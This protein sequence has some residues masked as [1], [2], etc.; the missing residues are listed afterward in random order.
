M[1]VRRS[2]CGLFLLKFLFGLI[3]VVCCDIIK[4]QNN[5]SEK[6]MEYKFDVDSWGGQFSVPCSVATEYLKT[7]DGNYVK[8]LLSILASPARTVNS[9]VIANAC[10]LNEDVV[11]DAVI[12]W[13]SLGV[14]RIIDK[15]N[16]SAQMPTAPNPVI[17]HSPVGIVESVKPR[18]R[19]V[20]KKV[21]VSYSLQE[22]REKAEKDKELGRL[23]NEIQ[24]YL[25]RDI[26]GREM[27]IL[28]DLYEVYHFDVPTIL[29]TAEYCNTLGKYSVPYLHKLLKD[30]FEHDITTYEQAEAEI[31]RR[32]E[33]NSYESMVKRCLGLTNRLTSHQQEFV[34]RWKSAGIDESLLEIACEKCLD[35]TGGK[36]NF[37][38]IDTVIASWVNKGIK[39]PEQ[40]KADDESFGG[41]NGRF[42][43][44]EKDNSFSIDKLEKI[45]KNFVLRNEDTSQ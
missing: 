34:Q 21:V 15:N 18:E 14:L 1:Y 16:S 33:Y 4:K 8:V 11:D 40:V 25:N 10:G 23:F 6:T 37:K 28:D 3:F 45:A 12:H 27:G 41:K 17:Q 22:I 42:V 19:A 43:A 39:T 36:I 30:W 35:G 29:I 31:V 44:D 2:A 38:Y 5:K 13:T 24:N 26:N 32:T 20:D 7:S 9:S